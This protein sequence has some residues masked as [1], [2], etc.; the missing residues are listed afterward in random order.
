M[1]GNDGCD[2]ESADD[3]DGMGMGKKGSL[4]RSANVVTIAVGVFAEFSLEKTEFSFW[5]WEE[6]VSQEGHQEWVCC[7]VRTA[8]P[9]KKDK[10]NTRIRSTIV[11]RVLL[12]MKRKKSSSACECVL[13]A[14]AA[15]STLRTWSKATC[16]VCMSVGRKPI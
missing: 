8:M 10:R 3:D 11:P 1:A 16:L 4:L 7:M 15:V 12:D 2:G 14:V 13:L 9:V 5:W 6:W